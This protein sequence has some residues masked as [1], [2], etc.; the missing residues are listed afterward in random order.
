MKNITSL[1]LCFLS[2]LSFSQ[3]SYL[4]TDYALQNESYIVST[5]TAQALTLDYVQT[6][7]NFNWNYNTLVPATQETLLIQNP[8]NVGYKNVW[9]LLNGYFFNCN[10]QFNNNFNLALKLSNGIQIQGYGISNV[11]DHLKVSSTTVEDR[12]IGASITVGGTTLPFVASYQTADILY[13]FPINYNDNYT[14]NFALSVDLTTLGVP[15]QYAST[16]QRT[17]LVEGWG[18]L[19]TP[20]GTFPN[21]LKMKTTV[22][23]AVTVTANGTP[24]QNTVTTVSYKW[25]DK[26]YGIPILQVDGNLVGTTWVPNQVTYFD[27]QRCLTP[28]ATFGYF[29]IASDFNPTTNNASVSFINTSNNYDS[30]SWNFGDGTAVST[31]I[32]PTHNYSCPGLKQ[33]TLTITNAFCNPDQ[34]D[35]F[36]IPVNI[37]DT[38]NAFTTGVTVG[39]ASL[40]ADRDLA[41]TTYQWLDC[42]NNN[43]PIP[44]ATGQVYT[45]GDSGNYAVQLT[46]NGCVSVSGCYSL[47][48]LSTIDLNGNTKVHLFPNPTK[49]KLIAS[50]N[51]IEITKVTVF[52][53]L[54]MQVGDSLDLSAHAAGIYIV[55]LETS[56]GIYSQKISKE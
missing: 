41:G 15:V 1:F 7:A 55:K 27:T 40:L 45:P 46:T 52:N 56:N 50:N 34:T 16:G 3:I 24:T 20:F 47:T 2:T 54:G 43:Q 6:G 12:M 49:G 17:N 22:V 23:N 11:M 42:D 8:N 33:V 21:V 29:P 14:N 10:T 36:T 39:D 44:N 13:Q 53:M 5:A 18:S 25:F 32:N 30:V 28:N 35:T 26:D 4:S 9:C 19:T 51:S 31:D 38:Q 37:T 48:T